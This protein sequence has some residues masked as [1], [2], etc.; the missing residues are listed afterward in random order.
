MVDVEEE[1][2]RG[3]CEVLKVGNDGGLSQDARKSDE[4]DAV[5]LFFDLFK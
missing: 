5:W 3:W 2:W 1:G 4:N